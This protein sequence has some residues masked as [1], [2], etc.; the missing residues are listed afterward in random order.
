MNKLMGFFEL[1]NSGLPAVP[2]KIF[3]EDTIFDNNL[4]W[5]IRTAVDK[6]EDLNLPRVV[7][8]NGIEAYKAAI[9]LYDKFKD[10]GIVVYYPY[11]IAEKSGTLDINKERIVIEAVKNDLWNLVTYNT[12]DVSIIQSNNTVI[13][14]GNKN[15]ISKDE[16]NELNMH[17]NKV[18]QLF[19]DFLFQGKSILLEWSFAYN[20]NINKEPVGSKYLVFYEI[21][22]V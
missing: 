11:F 13:F 9:E 17:V 8:I 20:T 6:G 14:H 12:K 16:L 21:R 19:R 18:R 7:G 2:W 3:N 5:T 15:F 1:Q 22:T 4:L 10:K